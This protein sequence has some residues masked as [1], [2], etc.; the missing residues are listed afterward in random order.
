M[1]LFF[2]LQ[3]MQAYSIFG[4][5]AQLWRDSG[6]S[7]PAT[8]VC[9]SGSSLRSVDPAVAVAARRAGPARDQRG[10][11]LAVAAC[12]P[13]AYVGLIVA[14]HDLALLWAV[15][16]GDRHLH[17]PDDPDP[18][19]AALPDPAGTAALSGF[20]QSAGYLLAAVGPFAVGVIHDATGGWGWPLVLLL[21]LVVPLMLLGAYVA[22]PA[23]IEDQLTRAPAAP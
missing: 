20:T 18:D 12:Y 9:W 17:V 19:R 10:I 21:S 4:W 16:V 22:R 8:P 23:Y 11:V 3:S 5:F 7:R 2:G 14:P 13:V 6:Y 1:V 15:V